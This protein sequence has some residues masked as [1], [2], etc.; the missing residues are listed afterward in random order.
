VDKYG[1]FRATAAGLRMIGYLFA[2]FAAI[3]AISALFT[4]PTLGTKVAGLVLNALRGVLGFAL[5]LAFS[6]AIYVLIDIEFN[7]RRLR[8]I[9]E[10]RTSGGDG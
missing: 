7:T 9:A 1:Q 2:A 10:T 6:E 8:E 3:A 4:E 5:L